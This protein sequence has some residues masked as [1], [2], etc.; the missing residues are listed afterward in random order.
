MVSSTGPS[1]NNSWIPETDSKDPETETGILETEKR[2]RRIHGTLETG[3]QRMLRSLVASTRG[4]GGY[5]KI[6]IRVNY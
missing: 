6:N 3:L 1:N 2:V 5:Q 4:G